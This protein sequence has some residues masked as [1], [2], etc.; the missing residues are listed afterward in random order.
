MKKIII[1]TILFM[2]FV[3]ISRDSFAQKT[4]KT[5]TSI[6]ISDQI[7]E[8]KSK[9]ASKV[10]QLNLVEKR[11]F[12]GTVTDA[13]D[14]QITLQTV[15]GDIR[16][17]DVDELT[18]FSSDSNDSFGISD[19]KKGMSLGVIG[20]FNKQSQRLQARL[21]E[22]EDALPNFFYGAVYSV[23]NDNFTLTIAK[24]NGARNVIDVESITK[25]YSFTSD[26][27]VKSGF[28]K[29]KETTP[30]IVIGFSQ[31]EDKN[32]TL[33]SRI[34]LFPEISVSAKINLNPS[35]EDVTPST[36]SGKKLVPIIK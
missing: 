23:D 21:V 5:P 36:G 30:V 24:E 29:I 19:V 35:Q 10:A 32:I 11:G 9:I 22:E 20:L 17:V 14:T 34:F 25:T 7:D 12:Y 8:L 18:K 28:S 27:L 3:Q 13:S 15:G 33:G 4:T 31:K 16:F 1:F 26:E 2:L 6:D